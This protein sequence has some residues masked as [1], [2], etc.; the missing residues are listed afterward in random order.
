MDPSDVLWQR[1]Q[2]RVDEGSATDNIQR[3]RTADQLHEDYIHLEHR[4]EKLTLISRAMWEML[5]ET[6]SWNEGRLLERMKEIDARDGS[7]DGKMQAK[8]VPCPECGHKVNMRHPVCVY[9]GYRDFKRDPF[10]QV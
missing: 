9:C 4:V 10:A 7:I 8:V 3:N 1:Y 5:K 2:T 6:H